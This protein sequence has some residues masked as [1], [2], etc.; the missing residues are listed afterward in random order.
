MKA[1]YGR[2]LRAKIRAFLQPLEW[3]TCV[4]VV[5]SAV[6]R[7]IAVAAFA[8]MVSR[9]RQYDGCLEVSISRSLRTR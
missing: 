1:K 2:N 5:A 6:L 7:C 3:A 8:E 9:A 4:R